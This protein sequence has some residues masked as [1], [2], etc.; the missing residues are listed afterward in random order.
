MPTVYIIQESKTQDFSDAKKYGDLE[1]IL[2]GVSRDLDRGARI[3]EK[4]LQTN[5]QDGDFLIPNGSPVH[6]LAAG[7]ALAGLPVTSINMLVWDR[8]SLK[9]DNLTIEL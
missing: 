6:I 1:V 5:W 7:A 2:L 3:V 4:V 9:Y 8:R